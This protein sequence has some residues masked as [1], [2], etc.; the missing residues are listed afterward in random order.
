ME[1][2]SLFGPSDRQG[3]QGS[4]GP[5]VVS[6]A[7]DAPETSVSSLE[8]LFELL[9]FVLGAVAA[10]GQG[11]K[12]NFRRRPEFHALQVALDLHGFGLVHVECVD[13]SHR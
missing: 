6:S 10:A 9:Q 5:A 11:R 8:D 12:G 3:V 13:D 1:R 7:C 2:L 4:F